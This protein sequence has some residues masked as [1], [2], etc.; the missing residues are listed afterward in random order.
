MALVLVLALFYEVRHSAIKPRTNEILKYLTDSK[1]EVGNQYGRN[2]YH[3]EAAYR[4]PGAALSSFKPLVHRSLT[5]WLP[6]WP[7]LTSVSLS[8]K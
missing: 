7:S 3:V 4:S 8:V 2:Y 5:L 1:N 6:S